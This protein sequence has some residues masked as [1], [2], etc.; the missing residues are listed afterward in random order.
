MRCG[1]NFG[2]EGTNPTSSLQRFDH[3]P[4][5][6][7]SYSDFGLLSSTSGTTGTNVGGYHNGTPTA[8]SGLPTAVTA[9][10]GGMFVGEAR[11]AGST[12]VA[13]PANALA[14]TANLTA[15]FGSGAISGK[16]SNLTTPT[17]Y[18]TGGGISSSPV[19]YGLGMNGTISGGAYTGTAGFTNAAGT[20]AAGSVTSSALNGGFY[21]PNATETAGA[22]V[23]RGTAPTGTA[24]VITGAFG[25]KRY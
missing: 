10:Y 5:G 1:A 11:S 12:A 20:A 18:A 23:V 4:S 24:T 3:F 16:V 13:T 15:N 19:G 22:L 9:T 8:L 25:A 14:G 21:G 17:A 2:C 7:L 6:F